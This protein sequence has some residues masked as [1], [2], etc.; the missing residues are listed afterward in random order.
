[1]SD[2][3]IG[4]EQPARGFIARSI[5][6]FSILIILAWLGM[7]VYV[8]VGVPRSRLSSNRTRYH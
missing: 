6:R 4:T 2:E 5:H 1:M 7:A 8:T 3:N